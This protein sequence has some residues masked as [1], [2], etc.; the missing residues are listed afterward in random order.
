MS[1][2]HAAPLS[3]EHILLALLDRKP[4]HGYELYQEVHHMP[5]ISQVWTI[6][7]ALL[8]AV[9]EKLE[10]RGYISSK[11]IQGEAYPPRKEFHLTE[12]GKGSLDE[13]LRTPVHR[14]RDLRQEFLAKLIVARQYGN[15]DLL[16][17]IHR[18]EQA[19]QSWG[20]NLQD[21]GPVIDAE[22]L[23]EWMVNSFRV[24][25]VQAVIEWLRKLELEVNRLSSQQS[26]N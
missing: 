25:Q 14:V 16:D 6:K 2:R 15:T 1:P 3:L 24:N 17:L 20:K 19:C 10:E 21:D 9:L 13:W 4:M 7:Q 22:H 18:Q 11:L 12:M 8:Y 26:H 23:D 5:G